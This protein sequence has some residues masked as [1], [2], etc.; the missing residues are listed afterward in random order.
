MTNSPLAQPANVHLSDVK[1]K[2]PL[3][4]VGNTIRLV[5]QVK[6]RGPGTAREV[7]FRVLEIG[8]A[9][10][11]VEK[12]EWYLGT[13]ADTAVEIAVPVLVN[14]PANDSAVSVAVT[15]TNFDHKREER[16]FL[17]DVLKQRSDVDWEVQKYRDPFSL[18]PVESEAELVGRA[19][20]LEQLTGLAYSKSVGSCYLFGQKR[21]GK[22]SVVKTLQNL[23]KLR[24]DTG[25]PIVVYFERGEFVHFD[26]LITV[27]TLGKKV[28][29]ALKALDARLAHVAPPVFSGALAPITDFLDEVVR[30]APD[31]RA[32]I[33][34]DE[35]DELPIALYKRT[36]VGDAFF[37]S[38][39][40][41]AIS[42][43]LALFSLAVKTCAM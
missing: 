23:L 42:L 15:W 11:Q 6:N 38:L 30:V 1:K 34:L 9:N 10:L 12:S 14:A 36:D 18:E 19:D 35:F 37:G 4:S 2:Y 32:L 39:E 21:V 26:P 3:L 20:V 33:V 25:K 28:C 27:E 24:R 8:D 13:L 40:V 31:F 29:F 17:F 7:L 41:S 22:T 5:F 43:H 16:E